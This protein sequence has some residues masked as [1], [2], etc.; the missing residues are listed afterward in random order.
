MP[1][2][3]RIAEVQYGPSC[4]FQLMAGAS[5]QPLAHLMAALVVALKLLYGLDGQAR[6]LPE[7]VPP[8][9]NWLH[10]A[11]QAARRAPNPSIPTLVPSEASL[12]N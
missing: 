12:V 2:A 4:A 7:G 3:V 5:S 6:R 1:A 9:P 8:P 11:Q 10:W